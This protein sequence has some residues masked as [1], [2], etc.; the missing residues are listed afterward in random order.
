MT[1]IETIAKINAACSRV[2]KQSDYAGGVVVALTNVVSR[3]TA[4]RDQIQ[5]QTATVGG[6]TIVDGGSYT[7]F[8]TLTVFAPPNSGT[9]ATLTVATM[10]GESVKGY[11]QTGNGYADND[12]LTMA[13]TTIL[14]VDAG[15]P[16]SLLP[17]AARTPTESS[18]AN[19]MSATSQVRGFFI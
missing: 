17:H 13:G 1:K 2:L 12:T 11:G 16:L 3:L 8:P 14:S 10:A 4:L 6:T 5:A 19:A 7:G 18:S 9:T 15:D